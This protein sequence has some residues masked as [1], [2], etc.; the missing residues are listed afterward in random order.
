MLP[1]VHKYDIREVQEA[2]TAW[3]AA[4]EQQL[5]SSHIDRSYVLR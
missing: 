5:T 4:G 3:L 2:C 1:V